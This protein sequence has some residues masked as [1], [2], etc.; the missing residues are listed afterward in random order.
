MDRAGVTL[1]PVLFFA[2][3]AEFPHADTMALESR[4]S[5]RDICSIYFRSAQR[6]A[7]PMRELS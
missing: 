1:R 4:P 3:H 7:L 5:D 6:T 2:L